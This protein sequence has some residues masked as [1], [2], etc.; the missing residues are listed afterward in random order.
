M[1]KISLLIYYVIL[2]RFTILYC[3]VPFKSGNILNLLAVFRVRQQ[4]T[5]FDDDIIPWYLIPVF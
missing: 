2:R 5:N 4:R 1:S 3:H